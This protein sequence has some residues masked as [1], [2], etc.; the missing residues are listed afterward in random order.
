LVWDLLGRGEAVWLTVLDAGG[1]D[2]PVTLGPARGWASARTF[3]ERL[4]LAAPDKA[5]VPA[6]CWAG[7]LPVGALRLLWIAPPGAEPPVGA[8][9]VVRFSVGEGGTGVLV[10]P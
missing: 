1:T 4:A 10:H 7:A 2:R 8:R 9:G 6:P 3:F 5:E